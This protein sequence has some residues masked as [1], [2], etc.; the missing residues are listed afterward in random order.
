MRI[1]DLKSLDVSIRYYWIYR[2]VSVIFLLVKNNSMS[3]WKGTSFHILTR[4]SYMITLLNQWCESQCFS[5][6]PINT[7]SFWNRLPS[8]FIDL[9][10]NWMECPIIRQSSNLFTNFFQKTNF[11]SSI[12]KCS[13]FLCK[14]FNFFPFFVFPLFDL[15]FMT[16]TCLKGSFYL[17]S[18]FSLHSVCLILSKYSWRHQFLLVNFSY[19]FHLCNL[20]IH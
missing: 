11:D 15:K 9:L 12:L 17:S 16:F 14:I 4:D 6:T 2:C 20:F 13:S 7:L 18:Y 5:S 8:G 19:R 10:N 1:T 3:V